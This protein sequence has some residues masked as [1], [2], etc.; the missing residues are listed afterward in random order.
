MLRAVDSEGSGYV[1]RSTTTDDLKAYI[2]GREPAQTAWLSLDRQHEEA[3]F[4][5][6]RLNAGVNVAA[7][8]TEFGSARVAPALKVVARLAEDGLVVSDGRTV[9]LTAWGQLLSND[10]FQEFLGLEAEEVAC[11]KS[12]PPSV[13]D[14]P[15]ILR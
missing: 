13:L 6:L 10:I 5:G 7:L 1:L 9:R 2:G 4:L 8:E 15:S 11:A 14:F 12:G 3:W